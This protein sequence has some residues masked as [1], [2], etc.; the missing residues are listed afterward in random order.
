ME[1]CPKCVAGSLFWSDQFGAW[2]C[3][4]CEHLVE[5]KPSGDDMP[6]RTLVQPVPEPTLPAEQPREG[7][8]G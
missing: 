5:Q 8:E 6:G 7:G 3:D 4:L 1:D 2:E